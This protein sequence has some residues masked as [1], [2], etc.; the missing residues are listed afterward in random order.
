MVRCLWR[1]ELGVRKRITDGIKF[2]ADGD[3][4]ESGFGGVDEETDVGDLERGG[5]AWTARPVDDFGGPAVGS[6][7]ELTEVFAEVRVVLGEGEEWE[8]GEKKEFNHG[9]NK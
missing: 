5:F 3:V 6:Y 4:A 9:I 7:G 2:F 1:R 8:E